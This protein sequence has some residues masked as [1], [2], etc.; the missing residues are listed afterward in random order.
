MTPCVSVIFRNHGYPMSDKQ[1]GRL[2][3]ERFKFFPQLNQ[4]PSKH[5]KVVGSGSRLFESFAKEYFR[6]D[7]LQDQLVR[8]I[9]A[10]RLL[11]I[12]E[13]LESFEFFARVR[14]QTRAPAVADL[15]CGHGLIGLL[16]GLFEKRVERVMLVDRQT[17]DSR[18]KLIEVVDSIAPWVKTKI[19]N[20]QQ[21]IEPG[22]QQFPDRCS[23][24][25][26][27]ACGVLSDMCIDLAIETGGP[28]AV[29]PCC[30]PR[31]ACSAP[32]ALQTALGLKTAFDV[33]RTYRLKNAGYRVRWTAIPAMISPMNRVICA[34]PK[35]PD[36][37]SP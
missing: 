19:E 15:C 22:Q 17:P 1:D 14:K 21:K 12:K 25:S 4:L 8:S 24:V 30:Y 36:N 18:Q 5:Q 35:P 32:L 28:L 10:N 3:G 34:I 11:P 33:D 29:L 23:V 13:V 20:V 37:A 9:A 31:A 6:N 16:F 27:H 26:A 2:T 7:T